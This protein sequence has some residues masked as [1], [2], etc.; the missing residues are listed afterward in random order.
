MNQ[1]KEPVPFLGPQLP[2]HSATAK[3]K[4]LS[5]YSLSKLD[6]WRIDGRNESTKTLQ[7][8]VFGRQLLPTTLLLLANVQHC[9]TSS[10]HNLPPLAASTSW[11][12]WPSSS[13]HTSATLQGTLMHVLMIC[14]HEDITN[15]IFHFNACAVKQSK[16]LSIKL[17]VFSTS[18]EHKLLDVAVSFRPYVPAVLN[19]FLLH[20][21]FTS[22]EAINML[23]HRLPP[24]HLVQCPRAYTLISKGTIADQESNSDY[25]DSFWRS[26][27]ADCV[28]L[29]KLSWWLISSSS[30]TE[31]WSTNSLAFHILPVM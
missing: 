16:W 30:G 23:C 26:L 27:F 8:C 14:F 19:R 24:R 15:S 13:H 31:L 3:T 9:S 10:R 7:D 20:I 22:V 25:E 11:T 17:L 5:N 21:P 28:I 29:L 2:C 6:E 4:N 12:L 1:T 18:F